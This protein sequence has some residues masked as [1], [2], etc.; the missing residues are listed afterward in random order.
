MIRGFFDGAGRGRFGGDDDVPLTTAAIV[1]EIESCFRFLSIV[2]NDDDGGGTVKRF[3]DGLIPVIVNGFKYC[4]CV[5]GFVDITT[6]DCGGTGGG[7]GGG[8]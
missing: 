4:C 6:T 5:D 1:S 2:D 3:V 7:G 8:G